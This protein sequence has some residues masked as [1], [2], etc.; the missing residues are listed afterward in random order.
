MVSWWQGACWQTCWHIILANA[1]NGFRNWMCSKSKYSCMLCIAIVV[2]ATCS[3]WICPSS[4]VIFSATCVL[5]RKKWRTVDNCREYDQAV[6]LFTDQY[7]Q[8]WSHWPVWVH[9]FF[10]SIAWS[11]TVKALWQA[12]AWPCSFL[13]CRRWAGWGSFLFR[14]S[15][16]N[17]KVP[18]H[19]LFM[20]FCLVV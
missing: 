1:R 15:F 7:N 4:L 17:C 5:S 14:W 9:R 2:S 13:R 20:A 10:S 16:S 19:V 18:G 6:I 12:V 3:L 11:V 8:S